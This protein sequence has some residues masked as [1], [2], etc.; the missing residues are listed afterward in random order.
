MLLGPTRRC[1][2]QP[3][4]DPSAGDARLCHPLHPPHGSDMAFV[5]IH[6][7]LLNSVEL[8]VRHE[9]PGFT[10]P[11]ISKSVAMF[12]NLFI[13]K[14]K[15]FLTLFGIFPRNAGGDEVGKM[16]F[17]SLINIF[18]HF[19]VLL[20]MKRSHTHLKFKSMEERFPDISG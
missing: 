1:V 13:L 17:P 16:V 19:I 2:P 15:C 20:S 5:N 3:Y 4:P 9:V 11:Q 8:C 12:T 6:T 18:S 10:R 7:M 14:S